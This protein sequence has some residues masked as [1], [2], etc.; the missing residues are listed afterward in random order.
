MRFPQLLLI[1]RIG[2]W[3]S[4]TKMNYNKEPPNLSASV[5]LVLL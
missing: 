2:F 5:A 3:G 1:I 4:Y